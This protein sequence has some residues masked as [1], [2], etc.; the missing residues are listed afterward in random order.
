MAKKIESKLILLW[1]NVFAGLVSIF[2]HV[3]FLVMSHI[4]YCSEIRYSIRKQLRKK[5]WGTISFDQARG[6]LNSKKIPKYIVKTNVSRDFYDLKLTRWIQIRWLDSENSINPNAKA[7]GVY[8]WVPVTETVSCDEYDVKTAW[9]HRYGKYVDQRD[10]VIRLITAESFL[11]A[12]NRE[13]FKHF[14]NCLH[15]VVQKLNN[16]CAT[17]HISL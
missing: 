3:A 10:P 14:K 8:V 2:S 12:R 4:N 7:G 15:K 9:R 6:H 1:L 11:A 16:N 13:N 17:Y 5:V